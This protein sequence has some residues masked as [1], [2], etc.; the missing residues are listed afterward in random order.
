MDKRIA[1]AMP[2]LAR[3]DEEAQHLLHSISILSRLGACIH[4]S[5]GGSV[6]GFIEDVAGITHVKVQASPEKGLVSQIADALKR[7]SSAMPDY[8]LYSEPDKAGFFAE[9]VRQFVETS[10]ASPEAA[11]HIAG[12]DPD[13]LA[14]FP[15]GQQVTEALMNSLIQHEL[16]RPGDY[17][18]GPMIIRRD[19][20]VFIDSVPRDL[21]WGWRPYLLARCV[22]ADHQF[23]VWTANLPCPSMQKGENTKRD[24]I[25]R[26]EQLAQN[27][28]G[29]ALGLK[30]SI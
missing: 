26:M 11:L 18:Y 7:A 17:F 23:K 8:I 2:T 14:T 19:I 3:T 21:G 20:S 22:G 28:R 25:Y 30:D 13:S 10:F 16:N 1:V 15:P 4:L 24:R 9:S 12:R 6:R 27:V 29:F 5:D